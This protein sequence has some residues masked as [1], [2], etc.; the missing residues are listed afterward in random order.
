[1]NPGNEATSS[2]PLKKEEDIEVPKRSKK[3]QRR[4]RSTV[5]SEHSRT[6]KPIDTAITASEKLIETAEERLEKL[7]AEMVTIVQGESKGDIATL[8]K[9]IH[10][11]QSNIND[12]FNKLEKLYQ[13]KEVLDTKLQE[14]LSALDDD[15]MS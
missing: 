1:M 2:Q 13:E 15:G 3:E 4:L 9:E 6:A 5:M 14:K 10:Q 11:C 8:S 12:H 7:N